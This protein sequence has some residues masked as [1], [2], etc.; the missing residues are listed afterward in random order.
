MGADRQ[1]GRNLVSILHGLVKDVLGRVL[2]FGFHLG[3]P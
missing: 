3:G 1:F 2:D